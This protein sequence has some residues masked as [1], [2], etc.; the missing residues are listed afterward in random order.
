VTRRAI[1]VVVVLALLFL[2]TPVLIVIPMSLSSSGFLE[3]PPPGFTT[4]WYSEFF[5][6]QSWMDSILLSA[7]I[8]FGA[9]VIA[10][11]GGTMAA[12]AL[13][14]GN[15]RMRG[16]TQGLVML[17]MVIPTIVY[18]VGAYL[19]ALRLTLVGSELLL[20]TAHA[21]LALPYVVLNLMA[22]I[23]STDRRLELVAQSLGATPW[24]AFRTVTLPLIA[25]ALVAS[26]LV[27][28]V[29]SLDET[30]VALFLTSDTAPTLPVK[31]YNSIRYELSPL[32]PVAAA[33]V[34]GATVA[35]SAVLLALRWVL[36]RAFG[37]DPQTEGAAT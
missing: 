15:V 2:V 33:V 7:R 12:Y 8:G 31:V 14:R 35:I 20:M 30:V 29:I 9:M 37:G 21:V 16:V 23:G 27:V 6:D 10:V 19:I 26:A 34:M 4:H 18:G 17:P 11:V 28:L 13:V 1:Q 22:S 25:P 3:F 36:M 5:A 32:V 24:T